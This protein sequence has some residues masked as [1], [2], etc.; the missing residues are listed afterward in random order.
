MKDLQSVTTSDEVSSRN[1]HADLCASLCAAQLS[2]R[3]MYHELKNP[4][5]ACKLTSLGRSSVHKL[6]WLP[7]AA[8]YRTFLSLP[9]TTTHIRSPDRLTKEPRCKLTCANWE[10]FRETQRS[11]GIIIKSSCISAI[12]SF[13]RK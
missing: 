11:L 5:H 13:E 9:T 1:W 8:G 12:E 2:V 10:M 6:R 3:Q 7:F 4:F